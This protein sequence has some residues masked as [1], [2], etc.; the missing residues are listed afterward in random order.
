[1]GFLTWVRQI[2]GII[3]GRKKE[4]VQRTVKKTKAG[5]AE[6]PL[7]GLFKHYQPIYATYKGKKYKAN[8]F[9]SGQIKLNGK[10]YDTPSGAARSIVDRGTVNGWKFWKCKDGD[11]NLV[12][13]QA[14]RK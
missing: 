12:A 6:K 13:V 3:G 7:K 5:K 11:G 1:L 4:G 9:K 10:L 8:V 2:D 14:L